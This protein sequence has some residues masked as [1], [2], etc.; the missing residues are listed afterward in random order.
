VAP[1]NADARALRGQIRAALRPELWLRGAYLRDSDALNT[2]RHSLEFRFNLHPRIRQFLA[3]DFLP[4]SA[5][6]G[7]F[8]YGVT[9][10]TGVQFATRVPT[11]PFVPAPTLLD[12]SDFPSAVLVP[13]GTR[14]SQSAAQFL[15]G[16]SMRLNRWFSWSAGA[17][18][19]QL[20]HGS[21]DFASMQLPS[22]D[23]RFIYTATPTFYLGRDWEISLTSSRQYWAYTPKAISQTTHADEIS[24]TLTWRPDS[25]S[26]I[27]L[28]YYHRQL[29]PRFEIPTLTI[30]DPT[31]TIPLGTFQGRTYKKIGNGGTLTAT[32]TVMKMESAELTVGY[33]ATAFGYHHP[34]G[35]L[36]SEYYVNPGIFT[37]RFYQ[38]HAGLMQVILKPLKP[39]TWNLHGTAGGQQFGQGSNWSF[40]PAAG[41]QL[42]FALSSHVTLSL[43]YEYF[44]SASAVQA[45]IL[46][47]SRAYHS[48]YVT[49][50]L[51]FR[52]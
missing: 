22:T 11:D 18:A 28:G 43:G 5:L 52:F 40:S 16:G 35:L 4:T 15:V 21:A 7:L 36:S 6:A 23:L 37:P 19:I 10:P 46:R 2:W 8:G 24:G 27:A 25:R 33:D 38:R 3:V 45:V 42:D 30:Y 48:N 32:R 50:G 34:P 41:S 20:R 1:G 29:S 9:T 39:V 44:N 31:F 51:H 14:F 17:G 26:R 13:G 49:A 12:A 47:A